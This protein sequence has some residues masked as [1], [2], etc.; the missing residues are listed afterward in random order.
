MAVDE[1]DR[2]AYVEGFALKHIPIHHAWVVDLETGLILD[3]TW[4]EPGDEYVGIP[5]SF[6]YIH[7]AALSAGIYSVMFNP[8]FRQFT[9][10]PLDKM[11]HPDFALKC[12]STG[13]PV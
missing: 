11:L 10:D 13:I 2:Y 6:E 7:E 5:F 1:P 8:K 4:P 3:P 9:T 12:K